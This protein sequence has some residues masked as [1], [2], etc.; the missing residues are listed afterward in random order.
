MQCHLMYG[1]VFPA[2][3]NG[4][5]LERICRSLEG[6]S[7]WCQAIVTILLT[8]FSAKYRRKYSS[9]RSNHLRTNLAQFQAID[10]ASDNRLTK[11]RLCGDTSD[12]A[13]RY[14]DYL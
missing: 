1:S 7:C 4:L 6:L 5:F 8:D 12:S 11:I 10:D 2:R 9:G 3:E 13:V 14:C